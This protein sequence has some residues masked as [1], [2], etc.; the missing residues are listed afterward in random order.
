MKTKSDKSRGSCLISLKLPSNI[1]QQKIEDSSKFLIGSTSSL[2]N[3]W[4]L[5]SQQQDVQTKKRGGDNCGQF[6]FSTPL[7]PNK[8]QTNQTTDHPLNPHKT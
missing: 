8:T 4:R 2:K 3:P 7:K 5:T 1:Q 6:H